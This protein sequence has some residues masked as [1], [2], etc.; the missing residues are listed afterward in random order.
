MKVDQKKS[1]STIQLEEKFV[2]NLFSSVKPEKL[3]FKA[4]VGLTSVFE[5]DIP[6]QNVQRQNALV[7]VRWQVENS[8]LN[9]SKN[10]I[11]LFIDRECRNVNDKNKIYS[12]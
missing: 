3:R 12:V 6:V 2:F 11:F 8:T 5:I 9:R 4:V 7:A 10:E 1:S